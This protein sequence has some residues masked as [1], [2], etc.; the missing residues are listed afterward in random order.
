MSE[1]EV[2]R[3]GVMARVKEGTLKLVSAAEMLGLSYRQSK[4]VWQR[5]RR[6]GAVGMVHGNAGRRSNQAKPP[7]FRQRVLRLV[8]ELYSGEEGQQLGPTLAAEHLQEDHG[9]TMHPETLRLWML[10]D[11]S[12]SRQ[13]KR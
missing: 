6:Q 5:Y 2:R 7:K 3:A 9:L 10:E 8:R 4:R 12:W 1:R 11:G 13:R